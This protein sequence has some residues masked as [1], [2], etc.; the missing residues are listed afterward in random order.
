[1]SDASPSSRQ[2]IACLIVEAALEK[3]ANLGIVVTLSNGTDGKI[4]RLLRP[5]RLKYTLSEG[6]DMKRLNTQINGKPT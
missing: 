4:T 3:C 2:E 6:R 1:M 5:D